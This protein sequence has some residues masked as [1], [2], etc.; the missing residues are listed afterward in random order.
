[1]APNNTADMINNHGAGRMAASSISRGTGAVHGEVMRHGALARDADYDKYD[2]DANFHSEL[3][4]QSAEY[5]MNPDGSK[6]YGEDR[7]RTGGGI[8]AGPAV[9]LHAGRTRDTDG[10]VDRVKDPPK[11]LLPVL[12]SIKMQASAYNIS[13]DAIFEAAGGDARGTIPATKFASTLSFAFQRMDLT[14]QIVHDLL[15]AYGCGERAPPGSAKEQVAPYECVAWKD[16]IEDVTK[17]QDPF[18][19]YPSKPGGPKPM[20]PRGVQYG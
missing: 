20:Y 11:E 7:W 12:Y 4:S 10:T 8:D 1:M 18:I 17:V 9:G 3:N 2:N 5:F 15:I 6:A 19:D 16:F 13:L 14:E